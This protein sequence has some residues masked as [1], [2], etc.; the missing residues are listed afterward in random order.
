MA[1]VFEELVINWNGKEYRV[2]PTM[3]LINRIEQEV[4]LSNIAQ[5][6]LCGRAPLSHIAVAVAIILNSAGAGVSSEE[7][8]A[9]LMTGDAGAA[10]DLM[11]VILAA[12]F[13][14]L[15]KVLAPEEEEVL[16]E[17]GQSEKKAKQKK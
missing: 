11:N 2:V 3:R 17:K 10:G 15:G 12:V 1:A 5:R 7:V 8:Y 4:S 13:P 9:E 14:Q 16:P 6:I